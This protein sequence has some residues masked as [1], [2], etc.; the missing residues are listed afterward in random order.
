MIFR[1][2]MPPSAAAEALAAFEEVFAKSPTSAERW[3]VGFEAL[4]ASLSRMPR[5]YPPA[6]EQAH[7]SYELRQVLHPPYRLLYTIADDIV[8][9]LHVRHAAMD[10]MGKEELGR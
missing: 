1:V 3:R 5:R 9:V 8:L 6:R 4:I 2:E 10:D 7:T